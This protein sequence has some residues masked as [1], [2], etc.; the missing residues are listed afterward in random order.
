APTETVVVVASSVCPCVG[1]LILTLGG[2]IS[3]RPG[4]RPFEE[5]ATEEL[6]IIGPRV[7][8]SDEI[9]NGTL[10]TR[11]A[12]SSTTP[13]LRAWVNGWLPGMDCSFLQAVKTKTITVTARV[14]SSLR[15]FIA[16][17]LKRVSKIVSNPENSESSVSQKII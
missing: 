11:K 17:G 14:V 2:T 3:P 12:S 9:T 4:F 10:L 15:V 5:E 13:L 16:I 7:N 1:E 6:V 8:K